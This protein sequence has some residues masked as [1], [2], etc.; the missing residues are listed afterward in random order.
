M[1]PHPAPSAPTSPRWG[2]VDRVGGPALLHSLAIPHFARP[3]GGEAH[4]HGADHQNDDRDDELHPFLLFQSRPRAEQPHFEE[5]QDEG[6][7]EGHQDPTRDFL[8]IEIDH[9][10]LQA[11]YTGTLIRRAAPDSPRRWRGPCR[12]DPTG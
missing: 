9:E 8:T 2:E 10:R 12:R 3:H 7:R 4:I 1:P 5:I 11:E 6:G